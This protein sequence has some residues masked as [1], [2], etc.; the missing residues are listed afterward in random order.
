MRASD[1]IL[2]LGPGAGEHGGVLIASGSFSEITKEAASLTGRYLSSELRIQLP[3]MRRKPGAEQLKIIGARAHNLKDLSVNIPLRMLVAITGVS[4]SGKSTLV[5]D[6]LYNALAT[7]KRQTDF[8]PPIDL[9]LKLQKLEGSQYIDEVVLVAQS[10]IWRTPRSNRVT[11]ITVFDAIR[12]L[13]A[14][15]PEAHKRGLTAGHF[16]FNNP[17]G[18]CEVC[19]GDGT[20]TGEMQLLDD[21]EL[22][23]EEGHGT[24]FKPEVLEVRYRGKDVHEAL[25]LTVKEAMQ[26]FAEIGRAHV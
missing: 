3:P 14:S 5:H 9:A 25:D 10:L 4:G 20:V 21:V 18:R 2:D 24:R 19:Q 6:V 15:Q 1:R 16:S 22:V 12:D 13:Y 26:L 7:A 11:Y 17:G 8:S 23:C